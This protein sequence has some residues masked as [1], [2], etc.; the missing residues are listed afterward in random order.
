MKVF[1]LEMLIL[2]KF[3]LNFKIEYNEIHFKFEIQLQLYYA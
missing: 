2:F 3:P 1:L